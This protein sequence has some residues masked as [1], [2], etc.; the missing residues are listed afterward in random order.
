MYCLYTGPEAAITALSRRPY[1]VI[2]YRFSYLYEKPLITSLRASK[3]SLEDVG[4]ALY[5]TKLTL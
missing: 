1:G 5:D 2:C 4:L 3:I